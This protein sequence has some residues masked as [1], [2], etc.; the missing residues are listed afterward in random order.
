M[1]NLSI[2]SKNWSVIRF[3]QMADCL[4]VH[5]EHLAWMYRLMRIRVDVDDIHQALG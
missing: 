5:G 3:D 4:S 2:N 1:R